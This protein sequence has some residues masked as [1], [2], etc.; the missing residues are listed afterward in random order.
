MPERITSSAMYEVIMK[1]FLATA[2]P[3]WVWKQA[4]RLL[5]S[6]IGAIEDF[7]MD[8]SALP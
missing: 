7:V 1:E 6:V 2:M 8:H 3:R 4:L 5:I